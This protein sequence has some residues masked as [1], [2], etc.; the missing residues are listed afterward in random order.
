MISSSDS[1]FDADMSIYEESGRK[2]IGVFRVSGLVGFVIQ[3]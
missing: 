2:R 3:I 1:D